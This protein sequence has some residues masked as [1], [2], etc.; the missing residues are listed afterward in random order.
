MTDIL[1]GILN[2]TCSF[3]SISIG[4]LGFQSCADSGRKLLRIDV[5]EAQSFNFDLT[6]RSDFSLGNPSKHG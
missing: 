2:L 6:S 4:F 1:L 3:L 5:G